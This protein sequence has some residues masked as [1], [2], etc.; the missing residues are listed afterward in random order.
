MHST[1]L[2]AR[3]GH[4]LRIAVSVSLLLRGRGRFIRTRHKTLNTVQALRALAASGVL[5][6][7]VLYVLAHRAGYSFQET[8][9]TASGVDLFFVISGFIMFYTTVGEFGQPNASYLFIRRRAIRIVPLY[10]LCTAAV[11]LLLGL[12]PHLFRYSVFEWNTAIPSFF[13]LLSKNSAGRVGTVLQTGW[14]LCFEFYFYVI[15]AMLLRW[16]QKFFLPTSAAVFVCGICVGQLRGDIPIWASVAT[17]PLLIEFFAGTLIA[18][19]FIR[20]LAMPGVV[21][22]CLIVLGTVIIGMSA[23]WDPNGGTGGVR[24]LWWGLPS[25][26]ILIG[27]ISLERLGIRVPRLLVAL[28]NS[29][30]SLYLIHPFV[31]P[32]FGKLGF[33][34]HVSDKVPAVIF[35]MLAFVTSLFVGHAMYRLVE[36]PLTR[37]FTTV[38]GTPVPASPMPA[39]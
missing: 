11:V 8:A 14:T 20:G 29:S 6:Y 31:L 7:H 9:V 36:V 10:W 32:V 22:V 5:F 12:F 17:D 35:G 18:L 16:P 34:W 33:V 2:A 1:V 4:L 24:V 27:A 3:A 37:Y 25:A 13:F 30:Y 19:L 26:A 28:G 15:F 21:A 39:A 23:I 38:W